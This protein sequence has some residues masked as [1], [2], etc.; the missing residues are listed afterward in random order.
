MKKHII[1]IDS[2]MQFYHDMCC[3]NMIIVSPVQH[4]N[5]LYSM[6]ADHLFHTI[7]KFC[8]NWGIDKYTTSFDHDEQTLEHFKIKIRADEQIIKR[9]RDTHF[10]VIEMEKSRKV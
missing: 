2:G 3:R 7:Q 8:K 6:K 9:I 5:S 4:H 10:R 1:D